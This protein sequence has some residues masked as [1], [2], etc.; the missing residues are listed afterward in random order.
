MTYPTVLREKPVWAGPYLSLGFV[1]DDENSLTYRHGDSAIQ[2]VSHTHDLVAV[3]A[4]DG[5]MVFDRPDLILPK[6][7]SVDLVSAALRGL[8]QGLS[9]REWRAPTL[10]Q[11]KLTDAERIFATGRDQGD[12]GFLAGHLAPGCHLMGRPRSPR[13]EAARIIAAQ[14]ANRDLLHRVVVSAAQDDIRRIALANPYCPTSAKREA[15]SD[16]SLWQSLVHHVTLPT[17]L[18]EPL[19]LKVA[20]GSTRSQRASTVAAAATH[21]QT[22]INLAS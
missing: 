15:L 17:E 21:P 7:W 22:P 19:F 16:E 1:H 9:R 14:S 20:V 5:Q 10:F 2:V 8:V 3:D 12:T 13:A 18:V 11:M 4:Y 6:H